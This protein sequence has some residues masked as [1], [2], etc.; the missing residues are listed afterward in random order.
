MHDTAIDIR[1]TLKHDDRD[2]ETVP[3]SAV[4][5]SPEIPKARVWIFQTRLIH[6]RL[7]VF[8]RLV[9]LGADRYNIEV[10]GRLD[11]GKAFGGGARPYFRETPYQRR[12][13]LGMEFRHWPG[14]FERI[15]ADR[16]AVVLVNTHLRHYDCWHIP[17]FCRRIGAAAVGWGKVHSFSGLPDPLLRIGKRAM[18]RRFD[19][20]IAYG[21][22]A[23]A[24]INDLGIDD[25]KV[26]VAQ[27]TIDTRRIFNDGTKYVARGTELRRSYGL[28][29]AKIVLCVARFSPE[30]R[31]QD[32]LDAWPRLRELDTALHL[33][34]VG[35][36]ELLDD[37]KAKAVTLDPE[38]IVVT[39]RVPE[40]E[41]Y[42]WIATA[43]LTVQCGAVGLA[44]NQSMAF[45]K[46]TVI[47]DERGSDTEIV[48]HGRTGWRYPRGDLTALVDTVAEIITDPAQTR[49]VTAA[50][51]ER[52]RTAVT[53]ENMA[54]VMDSCIRRALDISQQ[55]RGQS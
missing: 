24:E 30:K 37:I 54:Q 35:G 34:L 39:G 12:H 10:F 16:P 11:D 49:A 6:Y 2:D 45:G 27:N 3:T 51:R 31:L 38:R 8:D 26:Y 17:G 28:E 53:I 40:G 33:V 29:D 50:A 48:E 22:S 20:F 14:I 21:Q 7:P 9:Q 19:Y 42:A 1:M 46:P 36:G 44:I 4:T 52:M 43:D 5:A 23:R 25:D 41:D 32:L 47:A 18:F 13:I 55:R 15:D